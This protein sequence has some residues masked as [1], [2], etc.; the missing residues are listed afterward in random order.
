MIVEFALSSFLILWTF[1]GMFEFGYAF[2]AYN[3][4]V[5]AV[6][7]GARYAGN[8]PYA[9]A[10]LTAVAGSNPVTYTSAD[11]TYTSKVQNMVVYGTPTPATGAKPIVL[12]L[13]TSNVNLGMTP[14]AAGVNMQ[15]PV[16]VTISI[17][18]FSLDAIF[19]TFTMNGRPLV[20]FPYTGILDP[21]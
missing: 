2:Y 20:T 19:K 4:L 7:N 6:R 10:S 15:P 14:G 13:T 11:S 8:L 12:G 21:P 16:A 5:N 17:Q 9:S 1:S 18:N 3:S